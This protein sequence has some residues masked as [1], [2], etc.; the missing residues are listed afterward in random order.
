MLE[1]P[2]DK[3][4]S[5]DTLRREENE[6]TPQKQKLKIVLTSLFKQNVKKNKNYM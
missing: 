6:S 5:T 3:S 4:A 2:E 1:A